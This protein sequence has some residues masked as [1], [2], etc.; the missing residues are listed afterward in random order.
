MALGSHAVAMPILQLVQVKINFVMYTPYT[1]FQCVT[2]YFVCSGRLCTVTICHSSVQL[3]MLIAQ[4]TSHNNK[5]VLKNYFHI[6]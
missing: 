3:Q 6:L 5:R 1:D 2:L 4:G